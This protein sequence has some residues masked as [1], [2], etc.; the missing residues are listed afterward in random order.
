MLRAAKEELL[1]LLSVLNLNTSAD[2]VDYLQQKEITGRCRERATSW[3]A[4]EKND[5]RS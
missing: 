1:P 4:G 2:P 5:A 3:Q